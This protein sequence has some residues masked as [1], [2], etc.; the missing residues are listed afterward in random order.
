MSAVVVVDTLGPLM[1]RGEERGLGPLLVQVEEAL[2]LMRGKGQGF[3]FAT[4]RL[5]QLRIDLRS[6]RSPEEVRWGL[7]QLLRY[8]RLAF[9]LEPDLGD[10]PPEPCPGEL[11]TAVPKE[12]V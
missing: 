10:G 7:E 5:H 9:A 4:V 11:A 12:V 2:A 8:L 3:E 6:G 1:L